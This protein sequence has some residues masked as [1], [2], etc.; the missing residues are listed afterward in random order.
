[1]SWLDRYLDLVA[2]TESPREFHFWCAMA[3]LGH[4]L[5]RRVWLDQHRYRVYPGQMMVLLCS[6]SAVARKTTAT[7]EI[8][9]LIGTLP[10]V[11]IIPQ[12]VTGATLLDS[13]NRLD[14]NAEPLDAV[15]L[16][17]AEELGNFF[18]REDCRRDLPTLVTELN[19]AEDGP[20]K[21]PTRTYGPVVLYNPCVGMIGGV[22]K[23]GL[24]KEVPEQVRRTGF[25][26]RVITVEAEGAEKPQDL[27]EEPLEMKALRQW[28]LVDLHQRIALLNGPFQ[29]A[30]DAKA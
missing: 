18:T 12:R 29:W 19:D 22:T 14:D 5:G 10:H 9:K 24:A 3:G 11:N 2:E 13:L 15:G 28:L 30:D 25:L 16:I 7:R 27:I 17:F 1:M 20:W 8:K 4:V 26:G 6:D 23:T 21:A